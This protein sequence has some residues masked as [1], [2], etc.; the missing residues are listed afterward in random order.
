MESKFTDRELIQELEK[1]FSDNTIALQELKEM[2]E[3]LIHLNKRLEESEALKSHFLSNIRNE[4]INPFASI[5]ALAKSIIALNPSNLE[6]GKHMA[7]LIHS[8]A[9]ILDFQLSNIFAA[10]EVEAGLNFPQISNVEI[11]ELLQN[12]VDSFQPLANQKKIIISIKN[13]IEIPPSGFSFKTDSHKIKLMISNLLSNAIFYSNENSPVIIETSICGENIC[14]AVIDH[15]IGIEE[16]NKKEIFDRFKRLNTRI[17]T[18]SSGHGLGLS[19]VREF[20]DLLN[21]NITIDSKMGFG[22]TFMISIPESNLEISSF[23]SDGN[24]EIF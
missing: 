4:I 10:A 2:A 14:I 15:G 5:M 21:G 7:A 6:K 12:V 13:K 20:L 9:F 17:F 22:T 19:V 23:S 8:E 3:Q 1:R 18:P 24:E 11:L 16:E